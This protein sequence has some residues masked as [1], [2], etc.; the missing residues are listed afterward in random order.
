MMIQLTNVT[1]I[2][3]MGEMEDRALSGVSSASSGCATARSLAL[4]EPEAPIH[5]GP[6]T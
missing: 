1:E 6:I 2:Y 3:R 5:G 4:A